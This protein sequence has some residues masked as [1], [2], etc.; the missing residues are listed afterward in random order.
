MRKTDRVL[1]SRES[2]TEGMSL[3]GK[4]NLEGGCGVIGIASSTQIR[5]HHFIMP[6]MQMK[7]R[8]NGKGGGIAVFGLSA[9]ALGVT[10]TILQNDYILQVAYLDSSSKEEIEYEFITPFFEVHASGWVSTIEDYSEINLEVEPPQVY[11]YFCRVKKEVLAEFMKK[12]DLDEAPIEA[13]DEFVYQ[14]TYALNKKY[15]AS[16]GEK[17]AFVLSHGKDMLVFKLVGYGDQV[18]KYYKLEEFPAYMWIG[19]HRYPT[20]GTVWH[21]GGAHPFIG[22][23]NALVHNGDFSN[24]HSICEYLAQRHIYPLFLTDTEVAAYLF[25]LWTRV[26]QYPIEYVIEAM[27]PTT[28]RD[29]LMLSHNKQEIYH[30]LQLAHIHGSP[31]G[32]WFFIV[33]NTLVGSKKSQLIGITDTSMLRPQVFAL[34]EGE[35]KIGLIASERQAIDAFLRSLSNEDSRFAAKADIY[36][37][38]RGGSYTDGGAFIFTVDRSVD[39]PNLICTNKFGVEIHSPERLGSERALPSVFSQAIEPQSEFL[40]AITKG[41]KSVAKLCDEFSKHVVDFPRDRKE[42]VEV[43]TIFLDRLHLTPLA[44]DGRSRA[45]IEQTLFRILRSFPLISEPRDSDCVLIDWKTRNKLRAPSAEESSLVIDIADFPP[46]GEESA[47]MFIVLAYQLGWKHLY[48]FDWRGQRFCGCGLGPNS[49]GFRID[50]YGNPGDYL[51]SGLDGA[52]IYVHASAQDQIAQIMRSGKLVVYGDVGQTF[53]YGAKGGEVYVL[54]NAAG[55]PLINAVG[56]P[57]VV[58][59]G[60]CLDYLAESFMAGDP[61]EGGGFVILNGLEFNRAY[62]PQPLPTPYAGGNLFSLASGGAI[63]IR[64]PLKVVE[65]NQ[66]NGGQFCP[67][68]TEDW[69]LIAPYLG[70]NHRLFEI[71]PI[72]GKKQQNFSRGTLSEVYRKIEP[73]PLKVLT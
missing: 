25:D 22:L 6:L 4:I 20:K 21:P 26:Y 31:D 64:D 45:V 8:G 65:E 52:E 34:Q 39:K 13:E 11:R 14:N 63:Y 73:V 70:E 69:N 28:E 40:R 37:N 16:L 15:Y 67:L 35:E 27:A 29:F 68:S 24:Y 53:M 12:N 49:A 55:R 32:P 44:G 46:E 51:A 60:T 10:E 66:L 36:W 5:G 72:F 19:H 18:I 54:G 9:K 61:L 7:N 3:K 41:T 43:L 59:N 23:H 50:V 57:K 33:G 62:E 30:E 47:A 42:A 2:L 1:R 71:K 56:T 48:S 38:A 58:I 17:R